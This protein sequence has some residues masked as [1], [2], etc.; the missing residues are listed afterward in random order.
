[1]FVCL[2]VCFETGVYLC[3]RLTKQ[4]R[5]TLHYLYISSAGV[6]G[7]AFNPF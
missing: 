4:A 5:V 6:A 2:F 7:G 3:L 1:M